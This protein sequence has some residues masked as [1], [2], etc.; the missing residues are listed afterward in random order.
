MINLA[1][2]SAA[3]LLAIARDHHGHGR[4]DEAVASYREACKHDAQNAQVWACYGTLALERAGCADPNSENLA[5][6]AFMCEMAL[7]LDPS[8]VIAA[9]NLG[10][11][12]LEVGR[13][14]D[15]IGMMRRAIELAPNA[16]QT[17]SSLMFAL[18]VS[19]DHDERAIAD[20]A[21]KW[22][23]WA[24]TQVAPYTAWMNDKDPD[25][26]LR[27]GYVSADILKDHAVRRFAQPLFE[28]HDRTQFEPLIYDPS[29]IEAAQLAANIRA[30]SVDIV[31]DLHA[32]TRNGRPLTFA[33]RPAPISI[34][35][36][37]YAGDPGICDY[38]L[39]DKNLTPHDDPRALYLPNYWCYPAPT[40]AP[41][42]G[43]LPALKNGFVTFG[44][45]NNFQKVGDEVLATWRRILDAVPGSRMILFC[46]P[47]GSRDRATAA[48]GDRVEFVARQ[49]QYDY[50]QTYSRIDVALDTFPFNGGTTT[51]DALWMGVPVVTLVGNKPVARAG[52]SVINACSP[53]ASLP[54]CV[55]SS[56]DGYVETAILYASPGCLWRDRKK[57]RNYMLASPLMDAKAHAREIEN[58]YRTAWR[59]YCK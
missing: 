2:P 6:A 33:A 50:F 44:C 45:L 13:I 12:Y 32:H 43:P 11:A 53:N 10:A 4:W 37:A 27:I 17:R 16:H 38:Y 30:D 59:A 47:G 54:M 48:L 52:A 3:N 23:E 19:P 25:R 29:N 40:Q 18:Q 5:K 9:S 8:N 51:C 49:S 28:S 42:V 1:N 14:A 31:I 24:S 39:T 26:R 7:Q 36:L 58:T 46:P 34:S 41:E 22:C 57:A 21:A 56:V 55:D 15:A 20:E 35:Y